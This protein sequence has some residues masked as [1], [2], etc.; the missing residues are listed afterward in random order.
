MTINEV[1]LWNF[2]AG[3]GTKVKGFGIRYVFE[4][5][6]FPMLWMMSYSLS[7]GLGKL[8]RLYTD[9]PISMGPSSLETKSMVENLWLGGTSFVYD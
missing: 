4:F 2:L 5:C 8:H 3:Y 9:R 6:L 7:R 1:W